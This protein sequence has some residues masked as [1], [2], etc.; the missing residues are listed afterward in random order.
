[1]DEP[2]RDF[3]ARSD[4]RQA[5]WCYIERNVVMWTP[6]CTYEYT[7]K[8]I[9]RHLFLLTWTI[10]LGQYVASVLV[11]LLINQGVSYR[12]FG[13]F[14]WL[15]V[16]FSAEERRLRMPNKCVVHGCRS[17]YTGEP[18]KPGIT[19][20][21][22]PRYWSLPNVITLHLRHWLTNYWSPWTMW[23]GFFAP[24]QRNSKQVKLR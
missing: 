5:S 8:R 9:P 19:M 14:P 2:R 12:F 13:F 6:F 23:S 20:H 17:G 21:S 10:A 1:M 4:N 24:F 18:K 7:G 11:T 22:F 3:K 16:T 15:W